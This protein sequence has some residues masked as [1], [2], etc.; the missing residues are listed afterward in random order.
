MRDFG[1]LATAADAASA[2]AREARGDLRRGPAARKAVRRAARAAARPGEL[3][4][5]QELEHKTDDW[6]PVDPAKLSEAAAAPGKPPPAL[7][8]QPTVAQA[9]AQGADAFYFFQIE[10][11]QIHGEGAKTRRRRRDRRPRARGADQKEWDE[12]SARREAWRPYVEK[13]KGGGASMA[14]ALALD[15]KRDELLGDAGGREKTLAK[16]KEEL[17]GLESKIRQRR[18]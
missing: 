4:D 17:K 6:H 3:E 5:A 18:R 13:A 11:S 14:A 2:D 15:A 16:V 8:K 9:I 1:Y 10:R 7:K 12:W